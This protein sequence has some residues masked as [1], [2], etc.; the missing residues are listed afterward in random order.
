MKVKF[1][2]SDLSDSETGDEATVSEVEEHEDDQEDGSLYPISAD[3][4]LVNSTIGVP[5]VSLPVVSPSSSPEPTPEPE[6]GTKRKKDVEKLQN[7]KKKMEEVK[8]RS[9]EKEKKD[10]GKTKKRS[11]SSRAGLA[12]PVGRIHRLLRKGNYAERIGKGASIYL[13]AV[14]EYLA[15]EVLELAGNAAE[16]YHKQRINPRFIQLAIQHDDELKALL[17]HVTI[18]QGGVV[19]NIASELLPK[20]SKGGP[21]IMLPKER[22]MEE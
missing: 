12:F 15:A 10:D 13:A 18:S 5:G 19:P 20:K 17:A 2:N 6:R 21:K 16:S 3:S 14:L 8:K 7:K 22:K 1:Q 11:L 4:H 9:D